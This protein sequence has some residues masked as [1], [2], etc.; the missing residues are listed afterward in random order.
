MECSFMGVM[1]KVNK[2]TEGDGK[3]IVSTETLTVKCTDCGVS[4][5]DDIQS[6]GNNQEGY[7]LCAT[8]YTQY[9]KEGGDND[10]PW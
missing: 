3:A 7:P 9:K 4:E 10:L 5:S 6:I 2:D 8:C 1:V